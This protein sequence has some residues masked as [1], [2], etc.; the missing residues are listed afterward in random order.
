LIILKVIFEWY[1][2]GQ[3]GKPFAKKDF[4]SLLGG[5]KNVVNAVLARAQK[6][7]RNVF[8]LDIVK[9]ELLIRIKGVSENPTLFSG[10]YFVVNRLREEEVLKRV[11]GS[12]DPAFLGGAFVVFQI[13]QASPGRKISLPHLRN[14]LSRID[15]SFD[16]EGKGKKIQSK[17]DLSQALSS[18]SFDLNN[19]LSN[20]LSSGYIIQTTEES[21]SSHE[22]NET[23][24]TFGPRYF[25]E[26]GTRQLLSSYF[27]IMDQ[28]V[29][30]KLLKEAELQ[31]QLI[32]YENEET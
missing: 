17:S 1:L 12:V 22:G 13:I 8:G 27:N 20:L 2:V 3:R 18:P 21:V 11:N 26:V 29:D 10:K 14:H 15:P 24:V 28:P 23:M 31:D 5:H 19:T 30:D 16:E 9:G 4:N 6:I 7:L 25:L 32:D